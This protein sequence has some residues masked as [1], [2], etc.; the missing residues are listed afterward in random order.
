MA[1]NLD[2][3]ILSIELGCFVNLISIAH[4]WK[5]HKTVNENVVYK[6]DCAV[7]LPKWV[8]RLPNIIGKVFYP[9]AI[10][11]V[12]EQIIV[13]LTRFK[14]LMRIFG[15]GGIGFEDQSATCHPIKW[16]P[17]GEPINIFI[18]NREILLVIMGRVMWY[19]VAY[20]LNSSCFQLVVMHGFD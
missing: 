2:F 20:Y 17:T 3:P 18:V 8:C 7:S 4:H 11:R 12:L 9:I 15:K 6:L 16:R 5:I 14:S 19:M 1:S 10:T 13:W